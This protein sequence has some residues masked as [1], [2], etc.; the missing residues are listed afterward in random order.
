MSA[1]IVETQLSP[2]RRKAVL[3]LLSITVLV[4]VMD[5]TIANVALQSIQRELNAT[6]AGLQWALDAFLITFAAFLFTG[7]VCADRFGRKKTLIAGL[8]LL[9]VSSALAAFASSVPELIVW[10][11][12]M[13]IGAAVVPTVTLAIIVTVFPPAERP[14]AIASWAAAAG[15]AFALGPIVGGLLLQYFWWGS[16]FLINVPLVA[17]GVVLIALLVPESK[18]PANAKFD[19]I[20]VLLSIVA[21]GSLVFGIVRG[22]ENGDWL[23][24]DTLVPIVVGLALIVILVVVES[25]MAAPSLDVGLMRNPRFTGGTVAIALSFFTMIGAIFIVVFYYQ[26]VLGFS[27][28]KTGLL[29]L[30]MGIASMVMSSKCPKLVPKVGARVVVA[31]GSTLMAISYAAT[32]LFGLDTPVAVL[33]AAQVVFGLGWGCIMAPA[34]GALMSVVPPAKAGAG[35]AV[36][37]TVRQVAG[38]LGVAV[39]GSVLGIVYRSSMGT[40]VDVLPEAARDQAAGSIG[41][42]FKAIDS[43]DLGGQAPALIAA[44]RESYLSGMQVTMLLVAVVALAAAIVSYRMLPGTPPTGAAPA[45]RPGAGSGQPAAAPVPSA[46]K[47]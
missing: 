4:V 9:G 12:L 16:V 7:G 36:A 30:P 13:G 25:R 18:N 24:A 21:V 22:G 47:A 10:R 32:S 46:P 44:A 1:P 42:T 35:Q 23:A 14:K 43:A 17:V 29:M 40:S 28:L 15:V 39:V 27:P 41:G 26:A 33:I 8:A 37:Q 19:P 5:I 45:G 38:A 31:A 11:S 6:N 2:G 20:G 34:T 3:A